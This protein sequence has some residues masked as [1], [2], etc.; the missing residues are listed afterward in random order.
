MA[1]GRSSCVVVIITPMNEVI[2]YEFARGFS[3]WHRRNFGRPANV[4]W[5]ALG[6]TSEIMRYLASEYVAAMRAW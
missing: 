5:R 1:A 3:E 6:G 4:D 2:R